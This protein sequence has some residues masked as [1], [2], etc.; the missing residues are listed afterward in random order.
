MGYIILTLRHKPEKCKIS[1]SFFYTMDYSNNN[2]CISQAYKKN[3]E[4]PHLVAFCKYLY[5]SKGD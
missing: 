2:V 4:N 5:F 1:S 3:I